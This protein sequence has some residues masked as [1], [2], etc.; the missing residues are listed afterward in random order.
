MIPTIGR[1][2]IVLG[3]EANG[4]LEQPAIITRSFSERDTRDC[5]ACVNLTVL[6]DSQMPRLCGSVTLFETREQAMAFRGGS[7]HS[8]AAFWPERVPAGPEAAAAVALAA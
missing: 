5:P 8:L 7:P 1:T 3:I 6:P 2:V 4:A